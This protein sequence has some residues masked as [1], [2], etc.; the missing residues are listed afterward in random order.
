VSDVLPWGL[1]GADNWA[2]KQISE[3]VWPILKIIILF[4]N[5]A[6]SGD[7]LPAEP[8]YVS[9]PHLCPHSGS[10]CSRTVPRACFRSSTVS[11]YCTLWHVI[12]R[13]NAPWSP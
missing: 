1:S 13:E 10:S 3:L 6:Y 11:Q 5:P 4:E 8:P 9:E 7:A 2:T 12:C